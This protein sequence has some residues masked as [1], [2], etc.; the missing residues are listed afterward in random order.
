MVDG[1]VTVDFAVV[2]AIFVDL[3]AAVVEVTDVAVVVV[4]VAAVVVFQ[5]FESI[6][7][8]IF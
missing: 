7:W 2:E 3:V 5:L 1:S 8:N 4:A 6:I